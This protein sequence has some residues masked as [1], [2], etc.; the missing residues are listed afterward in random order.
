MRFDEVDPVE[1]RAG[2]AVPF[3]HHEDVARAEVV[4]RPLEFRAALDGLAA[5]FL[6]EDDV[7]AFSAKRAELA[8]EV[9]VRAADSAVADFPHFISILNCYPPEHA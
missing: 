7:N 8:V 2:G 1:H 5:G 6:A 3:C 9:L 4:D